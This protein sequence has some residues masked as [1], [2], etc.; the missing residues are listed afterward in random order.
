MTLIIID[1]CARQE[2]ERKRE[3]RLEK[4]VQEM[5]KMTAKKGDVKY[6]KDQE[7]RSE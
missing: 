4:A 2:G 1:V 3:T 5:R 7:S 6:N